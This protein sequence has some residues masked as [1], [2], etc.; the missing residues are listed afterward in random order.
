[1]IG[2]IGYIAAD[3]GWRDAHEVVELLVSAGYGAVDW[4]MEQFDPL[5]DDPAD[6][7]RIAE[8][9]RA[10]GLATPQLMVHQ[11]YVTD[12]DAEWERRVV[13]SE[14]AI[15][16]A[17][18]AGIPSV[19]VVTGP[20]QWVGGHAVVGRELS[21]GQAW[22]LALGALERVVRR[23]EGSGV[24]VCLEPCWGTLACDR[25]SAQRV[26]DR[27]GVADLGVT[28]DPSHFVMSGDD[29]PAM[30]RDWAER[31]AH[32]HLK[33]AF[34]RAGRLDEDFCFLLPGEGRVDWPGLLAALADVGYDGAA[35]VEFESFVL[36]DGPLRGDLGRA[37][38]L[39][40]EL[41]GGLL[42]AAVPERT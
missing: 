36:L 42:A 31:V 17:A 21:S 6:L 1:M 19:G 24:R 5:T 22:D 12:D 23:A 15:D 29:V 35:C 26:L 11:D 3:V 16:A 4:T 10:A 9:A 30:V 38:V 39:A 34:G 37:A 18:L 41:V 13:R 40:R 33:D 2:P 27:F 28:I 20:N 8:H 32:V 25:A 7:R 14:R